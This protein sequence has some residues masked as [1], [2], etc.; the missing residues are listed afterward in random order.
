MSVETNPGLFWFCRKLAPTSQQIKCKTN[1]NFGSVIHVFARF[2]DFEF[3]L[4][5]SI[6]NRVSKETGIGLAF[7]HFALWLVQKSHIASPPIRYKT[8]PIRDVITLF[9]PPLKKFALRALYLTVFVSFAFSHNCPICGLSL[10]GQPPSNFSDSR[11]RE[12]KPRWWIQARILHYRVLKLSAS[13]N[14]YLPTF[15]GCWQLSLYS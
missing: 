5:M 9:F 12:S 10:Y 1:S 11:N 7:L 6:S 4:V 14:V 3:L 15:H 2:P 8:K 13:R